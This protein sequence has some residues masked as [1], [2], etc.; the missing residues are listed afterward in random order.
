MTAFVLGK[1]TRRWGE[2]AKKGECKA[3]VRE[4]VIYWVDKPRRNPR[5]AGTVNAGASEDLSAAPSV[6]NGRLRPSARGILA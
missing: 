2:L 1:T 5:V 6:S 3:K 4:C